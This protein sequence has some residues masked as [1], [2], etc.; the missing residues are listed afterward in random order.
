M[1]T[2]THTCHVHRPISAAAVRL[3]PRRAALELAS[4]LLRLQRTGHRPVSSVHPGRGARLSGTAPARAPALA[5]GFVAARAL[6]G[7]HHL[8]CRRRDVDGDPARGR[9]RARTSASDADGHADRPLRR[10][11][12]SARPPCPPASVARTRVAERG[13]RDQLRWLGRAAGAD[14]CPMTSHPE[15][16]ARYVWWSLLEI[17]SCI[18]ARD[19]EPDRSTSDRGMD[20]P[21]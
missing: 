9:R 21:H 16:H 17:S 14:H 8:R 10:T 15:V 11:R 2:S 13:Q 1:R 4:D 19:E 5:L 7:H 12:R 20:R 6:E 3:Q 18:R